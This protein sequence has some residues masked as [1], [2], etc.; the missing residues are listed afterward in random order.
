MHNNNENCLQWTSSALLIKSHL[1]RVFQLPIVSQNHWT[2][3]QK[4]VTDKMWNPRACV[5]LVHNRKLCTLWPYV[6]TFTTK[7]VCNLTVQQGSYTAVFHGDKCVWD[8]CY[9]YF[10]GWL[11]IAF[12]HNLNFFTHLKLCGTH[13]KGIVPLLPSVTM[14]SVF[15]NKQ[16]EIDLWAVRLINPSSDWIEFDW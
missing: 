10:R 3:N 4:R 11:S 5:W 9:M 12:F 2:W 8:L 1:R 7:I 13:F 6:Q 16:E 14:K 15:A